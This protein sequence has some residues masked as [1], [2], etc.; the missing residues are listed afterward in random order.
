V[1]PTLIEAIIRAETPAG[2]SVRHNPPS[3]N[4]A[5]GWAYLPHNELVVPSK[6]HGYWCLWTYFHEL[7]HALR[8]IERKFRPDPGKGSSS[9]EEW[10]AEE[11]A[12]TMMKRYG[13]PI[14]KGALAIA[15]QN[16]KK[17]VVYEDKKGLPVNA[18]VR[19]FAYGTQ[20]A[21]EKERY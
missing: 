9:H 16:V 13:L 21:R 10:I 18:Q 2:W 14:H 15:R 12:I 5:E 3:K 8:W 19:H 20:K 6:R 17:W 11:F 1:T 4:K 7:G